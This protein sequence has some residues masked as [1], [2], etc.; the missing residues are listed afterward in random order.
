MSDLINKRLTLNSFQ[1]IIFP[2]GFSFGDVLGAGRGWANS[3]LMNSFL[4]DQFEEFFNRTDTFSFGVCN[5]CQVMSNLKEI[6]PGTS[7]WPILTN[8]DSGQFEARLTQVKIHKS[9]SLLFD[10]MQD[11][12]LLIPVAHGEGKMDFASS[13]KQLKNDQVVMLSLIHISEPTR[14]Y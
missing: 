1:G 8:N 4:K 3:I 13:K 5:G 10:D 12:H 11:S 6:I 9:K 7:S 2:G 14:P